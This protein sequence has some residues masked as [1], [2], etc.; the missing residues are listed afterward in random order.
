MPELY[1]V[2][3]SGFIFSSP[4]ECQKKLKLKWNLHLSCV[5]CVIYKVILQVWFSC[6]YWEIP[7]LAHRH[8][9][10][11]K[12]LAVYKLHGYS[13]NLL[14]QTLLILKLFAFKSW[15]WHGIHCKSALPEFPLTL[16]GDILI[17]YFKEISVLA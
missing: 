14:S 16:Q 2:I 12:T 17:F 11:L 10:Q 15:F 4:S 1:I 6:I 13:H 5:G 8:Y 3:I 7:T 9:C